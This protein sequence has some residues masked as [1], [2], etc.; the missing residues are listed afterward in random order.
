MKTQ[1][2]LI[3]K[4]CATKG[5]TVKQLCKNLNLH[6]YTFKNTL[7]NRKFSIDN[8]ILL[9]KYLDIEI[10]ELI[11]APIKKGDGKYG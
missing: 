1:S 4:A 11:F 3:K 6:Y 2:E 8:I 9:S 7:T 5:L 10:T